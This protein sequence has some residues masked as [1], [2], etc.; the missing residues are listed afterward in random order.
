MEGGSRTCSCCSGHATETGQESRDRERNIWLSKYL[1]HLSARYQSHPCVDRAKMLP[2]TIVIVGS[3][4]TFTNI[5]LDF[6]N[7][8]AAD[9]Q[10]FVLRRLESFLFLNSSSCLIVQW[11][12]SFYLKCFCWFILFF[13]TF[14]VQIFLFSTAIIVHHLFQW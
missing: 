9:R 4:F 12:S 13:F 5:I 7:P 6:E 2:L 8:A 1:H 10:H 11:Q 14:L 3:F